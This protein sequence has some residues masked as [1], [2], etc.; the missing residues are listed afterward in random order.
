[1]NAEWRQTAANPWF[2]QTDLN[3]RPACSQLH[4]CIHHHYLLLLSLKAY[5]HFTLLD[6]QRVEG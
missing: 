2:K 6:T 5:A 1:M 3:H 4:N